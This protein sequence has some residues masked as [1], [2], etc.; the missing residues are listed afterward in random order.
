MATKPKS[1][2]QPKKGTAVSTEVREQTGG[3]VV[4][5]QDQVPDYL[6]NHAQGKGRGSENVGTED[7][8]I[9]RLEIVQSNSP[10]LTRSDPAFIKGAAPGMLFNSVTRQLYGNAV[11]VVPVHY[12]KQYLVWRDRKKAEAL[13][14]PQTG[15]FGAFNTME[16]AQ[17]RAEAEGGEKQAI[18]VID[19][20]QHLC[21]AVDHNSGEVCEVMAPMPRTKAKISRQWNSMIK[22]AGGDRFARAYEIQSKQESNAKGTFYNFAVVQKGFPSKDLFKRAEALYQQVAAGKVRTVMHADDLNTGGSVEDDDTNM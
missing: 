20:P 9:P 15:F 22:L 17:A 10:C 7:L 8:V 2:E 21:L 11:T 1:K 12:T 16:E 18:V 5:V 19:T 13:R 4:L 6:R 14:L 3:A